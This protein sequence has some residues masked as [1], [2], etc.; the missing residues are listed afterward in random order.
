MQFT[1]NPERPFI[2][3]EQIVG[4]S[5]VIPP[6]PGLLPVGRTTWLKGVRTGRFP[7]PVYLGPRKRVWRITDILECINNL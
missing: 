4:N 1:I 2:K 5:K 6:V 3:L 7:K